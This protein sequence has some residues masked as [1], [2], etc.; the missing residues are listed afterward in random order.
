MATIES[1]FSARSREHHATPDHTPKILGPIGEELR[2]SLNRRQGKVRPKSEDQTIL[3]PQL[4]LTAEQIA[5]MDA[6]GQRE[7]LFD[8]AQELY[9]KINPHHQGATT[10]QDAAYTFVKALREAHLGTSSFIQGIEDRLLHPQDEDKE[11]DVNDGKDTPLSL[12]YAYIAAGRFQETGRLFNSSLSFQHGS[13]EFRALA[14]LYLDW[15]NIKTAQPQEDA[16]RNAERVESI[17]RSVTSA[18]QAHDRLET[19]YAEIII[20]LIELSQRLP[21][22]SDPHALGELVKRTNRCAIPYIDGTLRHDGNLTKSFLNICLV[23]I[24]AGKFEQAR[25]ML[26]EI[27]DA[28]LLVIA[29]TAFAQA[30]GISPLEAQTHL[31]QAQDQ[32][33][34]GFHIMSWHEVIATI[35]DGQ[36]PKRLS[37]LEKVASGYR[38]PEYTGPAYSELMEGYVRINDWESVDRCFERVKTQYDA[39]DTLPWDQNIDNPILDITSSYVRAYV[40]VGEDITPIVQQFMQRTF[41]STG[42][43]HPNYLQVDV[44]RLLALADLIAAHANNPQTALETI[45]TY[46]INEKSNSSDQHLYLSQIMKRQL[47][48]AVKQCQALEKKKRE[49]FKEV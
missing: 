42:E 10:R 36:L 24:K 38:L 35:P 8:T 41:L 13:T 9:K 1:P 12:G 20:K 23:N 30:K 44:A 18:M 4:E 15:T 25:A 11:G 31:Q 14:D 22:G 48:L 3:T 16:E 19:D 46:I 43:L 29:H 2:R 7:R 28:E 32:L 6:Y 39:I 45:D 34:R 47:R 27:R 21:E 17:I 40:L 33:K 49:L 37:D 5:F 26:P